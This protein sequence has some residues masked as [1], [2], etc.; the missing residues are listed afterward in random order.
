VNRIRTLRALSPAPSNGLARGLG[1]AVNSGALSLDVAIDFLENLQRKSSQGWSDMLRIVLAQFRGGDITLSE[2]HQL[3]SH[4]IASLKPWNIAVFSMLDQVRNGECTAGET[5]KFL[6]NSA[7]GKEA[8]P[9]NG[10]LVRGVGSRNGRPSVIIRRTPTVHKDSFFRGSMA[11]SI[12]ASCAAFALLA[13][14]LGIE[15]RP[16]VY[17]PEDWAEAEAFFKSMERLG[18][19]RDQIVESI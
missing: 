16:G 4:C 9:R 6:I 11:T 13:L 2:L 8:P 12:G 3:A 14:D 10:L 5:L 7:R 18:C 1:A 17:C 19:P 15:G